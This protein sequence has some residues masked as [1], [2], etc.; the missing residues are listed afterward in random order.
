MSLTHLVSPHSSVHWKLS[1]YHHFIMAIAF[2]FFFFLTARIYLIFIDKTDK[3]PCSFNKH[4][5]KDMLKLILVFGMYAPPALAQTLS[6][7]LSL[8]AQHPISPPSHQLYQHVTV[9]LLKHFTNLE[10]KQPLWFLKSNTH[11]V[12]WHTFIHLMFVME[13]L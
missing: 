3:H 1:Q 4:H 9:K 12:I 8:Y 2:N 13:C 10:Q 11:F 5:N 7:H 6:T